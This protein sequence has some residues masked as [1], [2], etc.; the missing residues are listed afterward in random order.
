MPKKPPELVYGVE[1]KP[2]LLTCLLLGLQHIFIITI[3]LVFPVVIVRSIG[4]TPEQAGFF[5]S[6]SM[7]ASGVG[8]I[9]QALKKKGIGSGYLCPSV[10]GPSYLPASLLAAQTG[11]LSL[12]FG[13]TAIAGSF[14]VLLSRVMHRL[15]ALFP[16]EVTGLVVLMVGIAIIPLVIRN[17]MGIDATDT[18]TEI[19]ELIVGFIT[20]GTMVGLNVWGKGKLKLYSVLIGM[21]LGYI[22]AFLLGILNVSHI[23]LFRQAPL[24]AFPN[25][26]YFGWSFDFFL[27][28]PFLI[29][30]ICSSLKS[31]GDITTCQKINDVEWKRPDMENIGGGILSDGLSAI[32]SGL[33]GGMGQSTSSSNVGL[34]IGTGATSRRIAFAAGGIL[35]TLALFPKLATVFVIMPKPVMG[36]ALIY[37]VSFMIV[38]GIQIIM[39]RM[40]DARRIFV[41]GIPLIFGLS[42]DALPELYE[43][44][45]HPWLQPIFSSSLFLATMLVIILNLIF[46]IGI[47]KR[48]QLILEPGVD[49][50]EEIFTF[51]EKQGSAW[52]A[53]KEVI[54]RA[55]SAMNELFESVSTLGLAKGKIKADVSFDEFNLD[56][57][58]RYDGMQMEFPTMRPAETDLLRDEKATVKLSGF[59][60]TQYVDTVKS[61][62][63]EGL[64]RV[65]FHFDH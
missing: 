52:G 42:V 51:M 2:P 29:A 60:I 28:V 64:C 8:T 9:L 46:R 45:H 16:T 44:I 10:C 62:L 56:I 13:M 18:V 63:K 48:Q 23:E 59:M 26:E 61:E 4:G 55:I 15:R 14:E 6:M 24:I 25:P 27:L 58:L 65:Q 47:A 3:V 43:N 37:A 39:S 1:D 11:G 33:V 36:A 19:P 7:L 22:A 5:V 40:L 50:S 31:V 57:D 30:I 49:S 20:L 17:F 54:Y 32:V 53:R 41:V 21:I 34:S 38:A 12:L 35:I